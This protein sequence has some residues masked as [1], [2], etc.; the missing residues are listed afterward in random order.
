MMTSE[1][2]KKL[3]AYYTPEEVTDCLS[4]WAIRQRGDMVLE[5]SFGGCNFLISSIQTLS[6]LGSRHPFRHI[7]GFDIDTSAFEILKTKNLDSKNFIFDDFLRFDD[8]DVVKP[9]NVVLGNP[10]YVPVHKLDE[11]YK[12]FL[13]K[14]FKS[15]E[16]SIRK[17][18]GLWIYFVVHSLKFLSPGGRMA[19]VL[20]DSLAFT[21]YGKSFLEQIGKQFSSVKV[22]RIEER[23]FAEVGTKEKTAFLL[24]D[25]FK[26]GVSNP[27]E[28]RFKFLNEALA[29]VSGAR[30]TGSYFE[31]LHVGDNLKTSANFRLTA[32]GSVFDIRIGIVIGA[33]DRLVFN[34][35]SGENSPYYPNYLYPVVTKGK[36]LKGIV[37]NQELLNKDTQQMPFLLLDAVKLEELNPTLFDDLIKEIPESVLLNQTFRKRTKLFGYDDFKHPDAFLTF[38]SQGLPKLVINEGRELNCTNSVHRLFFKGQ[39]NEYLLKFI[40]IQLYGGIL[41]EQIHSLARPYGNSIRKFEPS[42]ARKIPVFIPTEIN[43]NLRKEIDHTMVLINNNININ[44]I[45]AARKIAHNWITQILKD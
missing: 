4:N 1:Q 29:Y 28:I 12:K 33:T 23:Y 11:N 9:V 42:D 10:P 43:E 17:R 2:Q 35:Q 40:A 18:S 38:F 44:N 7:F 45:T 6:T 26:Q 13:F 19:W 32:L 37:I 41:A 25:G 36:Q 3:G 27:E 22:V 24:C 16:I 5:P 34:Q 30:N 14:K 31:N 39:A 20:P 15:N 21:D 8:L